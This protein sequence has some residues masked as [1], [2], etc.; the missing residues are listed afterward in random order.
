[1]QKKKFFKV[2]NL[3]GTAL[4]LALEVVLQFLSMIIPTPVMMN[5][6]LIPITIGAI[7]YGPISGG[8]LGLACGLIILLTPNTVTLFM[9]ISP[10][11][12]I[13]TCLLKTSIAGLLAGLV[14]I[15]FKKNNQSVVGSIISSI[16]VPLFNTLIFSIFCFIFFIEG[17]KEIGFN[18]TNYWSI[19]T[20]FIGFNF[21]IEI[22]SNTV[23]CPLIVRAIKT[24]NQKY[25]EENKEKTH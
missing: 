23:I 4:L 15:P 22:I 8:F 13:I 11:A 14:Y 18:L 17:L 24:N 10:A 7:V 12:T 21:V 20:G 9:S 16:I 3:V 6:S 5:L 19:F 1:M 25:R 2:R